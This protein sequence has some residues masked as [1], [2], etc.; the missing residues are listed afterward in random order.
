[1][2]KKTHIAVGIVATLPLLN[3]YPKYAFIGI[4]GAIV[5]DWDLLLGIK[6]RTITHSLIALCLATIVIALCNFN[7]G[8][9]F[10]LNYLLHLLLDSLTKMGVPFFYPFR[11]KYYGF[12]LIK[13]GGVE[14]LFI[15]LMAILLIYYF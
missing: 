3:I 15:C 9:V 14:D 11:K 8:I 6:H 10:G 13:T 1:M 4:I 5:A 2:T 7:I 12:K